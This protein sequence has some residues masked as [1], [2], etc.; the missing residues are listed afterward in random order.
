[1]RSFVFSWSIPFTFAVDFSITIMSKRGELDFLA[2]LRTEV[3]FVLVTILPSLRRLKRPLREL[4]RACRYFLLKAKQVRGLRA[5]QECQVKRTKNSILGSE[6]IRA[7][8]GAQS[9]TKILAHIR[10]NEGPKQRIDAVD[11]ANMASDNPI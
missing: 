5:D 6:Q 9:H 3:I 8:G 1:M 2:V 7:G 10:T 11:A 4:C